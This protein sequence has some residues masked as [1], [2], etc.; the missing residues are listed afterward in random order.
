M[1]D[2]KKAPVRQPVQAQVKTNDVKPPIKPKTKRGIFKYL[3]AVFFLVLLLGT[4]FAAGVYFN[5]INMQQLAQT[6]KLHDY[7]F[8]SKYF[9]KTQTNFETVP[10]EQEETSNQQGQ[11]T[12]QTA[13]PAA[14]VQQQLSEKRELDKIELEKQLKARQQEEAKKLSKL[15][16][17]YGSMKPDE[18]VSIMN[19]LEDDAVL[20]ILSR[21]EEEQVAKILALF[22]PKRAAHLTQEMMKVKP[23]PSSV[24]AI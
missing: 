6:Y 1:V 2:K 7:P 13:P 18:A 11:T 8:L 20:A 9:P 23:F 3:L 21:M 5:F 10:L 19:Q 16:R 24:S 4:G 15:A 17:L 12:A 14:N 22:E